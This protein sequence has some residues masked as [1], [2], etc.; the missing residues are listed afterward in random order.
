[1]NLFGLSFLL[2]RL[3]EI[4]QI[5]YEGNDILPLW[6][7]ESKTSLTAKNEQTKNAK[8][9]RPIACLNL[10]YKVYTSCLKTFLT[11]HCD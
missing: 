6:L 10:T 4:Y 1:M 5:T 8:N 9:Y 3:T 7:T 2:F 11:D